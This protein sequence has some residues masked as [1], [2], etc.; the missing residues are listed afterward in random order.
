MIID[1]LASKVVFHNQVYG[2]SGHSRNQPG[3]YPRQRFGGNGLDIVLTTQQGENIVEVRGGESSGDRTSSQERII[4]RR[5]HR[6]PS[7]DIDMD[8][9]DSKQIG[10]SKT[11]EFE[12][13][14][15][16]DPAR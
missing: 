5:D 10:I 4:N 14:T 6:S 11:V 1:I 2:S 9:M 7:S 16:S 3:A 15:S 13:R 8:E 12:V